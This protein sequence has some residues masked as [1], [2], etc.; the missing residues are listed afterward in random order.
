MPAY[1]IVDIKISDPIQ[2]EE[3][4]KLTP[5]SIAA[6]DGRFIV[7]G[8]KTENLEGNWQPE[9]I[10]IL[11]FPSVDRAKQWWN[12]AEYAPAKSVRQKSATTKMIV[13]EGYS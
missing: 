12:S 4:K 7:R 13:V 9:R 2:Y 5:S 8:G 10:V 3:Y 1:V 11:E 6:F